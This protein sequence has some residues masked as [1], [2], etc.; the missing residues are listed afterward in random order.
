MCLTHTDRRIGLTSHNIHVYYG[1]GSANPLGR[2]GDHIMIM[3]PYDVDAAEI[4]EIVN[5]VGDLIETYFDSFT[6]ATQP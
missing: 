6:P 1:T 5:L 3:P 4:D 2:E